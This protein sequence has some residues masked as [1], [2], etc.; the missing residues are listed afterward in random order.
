VDRQRDGERR[1]GKFNET[2]IFSKAGTKC[3][4]HLTGRYR[5]E[6]AMDGLNRTLFSFTA[7]NV[8]IRRGLPAGPGAEPPEEGKETERE[9]PFLF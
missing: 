6:A 9:R 7:S 8:S 3:L 5:S 2:V 4:R 1:D